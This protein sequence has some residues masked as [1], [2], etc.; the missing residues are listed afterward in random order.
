MRMGTLIRFPQCRSG[1]QMNILV[2]SKSS[3]AQLPSEGAR[4]LVIMERDQVDLYRYL[5]KI[6]PSPSMW[7]SSS[8][9]GR[10]IE[11]NK[12]GC[13]GCQGK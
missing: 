9:G 5:P 3:K 12:P 10:S 7:K 6:L 4:L 2:E 8:T 11:G 1:G 13:M